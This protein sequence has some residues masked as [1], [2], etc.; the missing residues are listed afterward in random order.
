MRT[1]E[2]PLRDSWLATDRLRRNSAAGAGLVITERIVW[3]W[4]MTIPAAGQLVVQRGWGLMGGGAHAA[5]PPRELPL[6]RVAIKMSKNGKRNFRF[7]SAG[8]P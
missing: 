6:P 8:E 5:P 4:M 3:A 7:W 2:K 1:P